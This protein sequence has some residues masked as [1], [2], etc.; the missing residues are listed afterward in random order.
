MMYIKIISTY[1]NSQIQVSKQY[2]IL[3]KSTFHDN[4]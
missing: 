1:F 4:F 3:C 2:F